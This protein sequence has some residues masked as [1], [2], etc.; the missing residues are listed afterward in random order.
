MFILGVTGGIACGKSSVSRE[1]AKYGGK[2]ISADQLA[3]DLSEPGEAI[4]NAYVERYGKMIL[5]D[6]GRLDRRALADIIFEFESERRWAD[7][8]IHPIILNR[9]RDLLEQYQEAGISIVV[10]DVPLLFEAG[11]DKMADEVWVAWLSPGKQLSRL[12]YRNHL[13]RHEAAARIKAQMNMFARRKLADVVINNNGLR[14]VVQRRIQRIMSK[15]FP[16]LIYDP[17]CGDET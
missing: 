15:K 3:H 4:Y 14:Q 7:D 17:N 11:W 13:S 6:N 12:M 1:I 5:F 10:L 2:I 9:V 8:T 16:H